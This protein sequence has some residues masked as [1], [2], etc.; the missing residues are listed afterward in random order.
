[1]MAIKLPS[2]EQN[3]SADRWFCVEDYTNVASPVLIL[4]VANLTE[5]HDFI[6]RCRQ[7]GRPGHFRVNYSPSMRQYLKRTVS[8]AA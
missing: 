4:P 5:C 6:S 2:H 3:R 8:Q 7:Q 1:M